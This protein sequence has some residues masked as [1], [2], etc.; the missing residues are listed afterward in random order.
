[1][2][3]PYLCDAV[4]LRHFGT[5]G[6][7]DILET[8]HGH[9]DPPHWTQAVADEIRAAAGSDP[10]CSAILAASWLYVPVGPELADLSGILQLQIGLNDGHRPPTAHAGEAEGIYFAQKLSGRFFTDDN[11]AYDF[12]ANR[13]GPGRVFDTIDILRDAVASGD[14]DSGEALNVVNAMRNSARF[15][16]RVHPPTLH[17]RYFE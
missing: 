2:T 8:R 3:E 6:R 17:R 14:M 1:M 13:L 7:L 12:A 5:I 15:L 4:T 16:R 9:L 11:G 10:G